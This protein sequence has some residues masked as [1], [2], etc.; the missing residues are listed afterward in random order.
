MPCAKFYDDHMNTTW[1]KADWNF[2]Q[3][4][5]IMEK[6]FWNVP[7]TIF[8]TLLVLKPEYSGISSV[9]TIVTDALAPCVARTSAVMVLTLQC[10]QVFVF[11]KEGFQLFHVFMLSRC[12]EIEDANISSCFLKNKFTKIAKCAHKFL[13]FVLCIECCKG[14]TEFC[15]QLAK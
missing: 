2:H 8:S 10:E 6:T 15:P 12:L 13:T 7:L 4:W 11:H 3:I 1:I 9:N 14:I 5:I